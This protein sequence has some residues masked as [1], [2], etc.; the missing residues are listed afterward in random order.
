MRATWKYN[1]IIFGLLLGIYIGFTSDSFAIGLIVGVIASIAI[2]YVWGI[3][4]A[5]LMRGEDKLK[6]MVFHGGKD[7]L[8]WRLIYLF[9]TN[10]PIES[11][12]NSFYSNIKTDGLLTKNTI[13]A[14]EPGRMEYTRSNE[15]HT[16]FVAEIRFIENGVALLFS[17]FTPSTDVNEISCARVA[18]EF[19]QS[20]IDS[21]RVIDPNV[22]VETQEISGK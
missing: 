10:A 16:F 4:E 22:Y 19:V 5:G 7:L 6:D 11:I 13:T 3:A 20:V 8:D 1:G 15:V 21:I 2:V 18:S 12:K 14:D 17:S 9:D